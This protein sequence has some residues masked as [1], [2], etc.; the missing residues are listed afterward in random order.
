MELLIWVRAQWDRVG[1]GILAALGL[2][3]L[4][5]GWFGVSGTAY[6]AEQIPF[7]VSGGFFGLFCLGAAATLWLSADL[8]DDWRKLDHVEEVVRHLLDEHAE[9]ASPVAASPAAAL[10]AAALP[11][12]GANGRA[13]KTEVVR[14][15]TIG[16]PPPGGRT[17][18]RAPS[19]KVGTLERRKTSLPG[20]AGNAR[21]ANNEVVRSPVRRA[22]AK[23]AV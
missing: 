2:L 22:P 21:A 15:A 12:A 20:V 17:V 7:I 16:S 9:A 4:L 18:R 8:R 19:K 3:G 14:P 5:I 1:S 13:A 23:K 11:A 6:P 10:P